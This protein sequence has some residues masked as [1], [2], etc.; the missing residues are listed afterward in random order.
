[1]LYVQGL[2]MIAFAFIGVALAVRA[3]RK[4]LPG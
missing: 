3:F 4:E 2:L 1:V